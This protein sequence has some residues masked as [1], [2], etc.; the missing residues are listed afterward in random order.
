MAGTPVWLASLSRTSPITRE[1]IAT[2]RC[3]QRERDG[4]AA[5]LR[6]VLADRGDLSRE[7]HFRMNLTYCIHRAISTEEAAALPED[8]W[9]GTV[10]GLAGAPVEVLLETEAGSASTRP[11]L[12][13]GKLRLGFR[14]P[15]LWIPVDCG[16]CPSCVA[17]AGLEQ[18]GEG[19]ND[20]HGD[21]NR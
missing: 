10:R 7:R 15:D 14:D 3:T 2:G 1:P 11:C 21:G 20:A 16:S 13:P 18:T 19:V 9:D 12:R 8:F 5:L 4:A 6:D 17:R